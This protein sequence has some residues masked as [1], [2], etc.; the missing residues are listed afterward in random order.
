M[1]EGDMLNTS[2]IRELLAIGIEHVTRGQLWKRAACMLFVLATMPSHA[3]YNANLSGNVTQ[4][5]TYDS[6]I[7]LISLD[8][9]PTANGSCTA[10]FF[11][12]DPS[13]VANSTF[14]NDAAGNRM[15][16]RLLEAYTLGQTVNVGF[17]NAANCGAMGYIRVYRIG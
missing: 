1:W 7:V 12:L 10:T 14:A 17:D 8:D 3:A 11:E 4:I 16:A 15:Y 5:L 2:R 13:N 6:G 9:Q